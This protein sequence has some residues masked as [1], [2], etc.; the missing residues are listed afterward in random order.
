MTGK[1]T[2]LHAAWDGKKIVLIGLSHVLMSP[3]S[4]GLSLVSPLVWLRLS[5]KRVQC[6]KLVR[7][8]ATVKLNRHR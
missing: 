6:L 5:F 1:E 4:F 2:P 7:I 8:P 3:F